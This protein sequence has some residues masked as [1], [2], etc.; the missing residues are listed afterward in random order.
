MSFRWQ[1]PILPCLCDG[2][3]YGC[4][5]A[6]GTNIY[7]MTNGATQFYSSAAYLAWNS[8][9]YIQV[10]CKA[11]EAC[12]VGAP[13]DLPIAKV[14]TA[15]TTTKSATTTKSTAKPTSCPTG[16]S[17]CTSSGICIPPGTSCCASSYCP[18]GQ[19][20][21]SNSCCAPGYGCS[22]NVH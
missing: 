18:S 1:C 20:C 14:T 21:C 19:G 9:S 8:P 17:L 4:A 3:D 6:N 12:P 2:F 10:D 22:N 13:I 16:Q 5:V 15:T 11:L 7:R